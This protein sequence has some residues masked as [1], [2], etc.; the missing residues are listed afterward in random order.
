VR[1]EKSPMT[2]QTVRRLWEKLPVVVRA[3]VVGYL[4]AAI[5][6][7]PPSLFLLGNL[8]FLPAVPWLLP[9]TAVWLWLF[10]QYCDGKGWPRS[11]AQSR[12]RD[13]RGRPLPLRLWLWSLVAGSLGMVAMVG[14]AFLTP[15][16]AEIP[17]DAFKLPID[18]ADY[19]AWTVAAMLLAISAVAG[20]VEE[21]A[22]RGYMLSP[23]QRR[24][25]WPVAILITGLVFFADHHFGHAYATYA[26][27]PFFLAVSALHGLLVYLTRSILPSVVLH[28][29]ADALVIPIQY[30][31]IGNLS[32]SS[33][34]KHG[35]DASF[36]MVLGTVV[37]FGLA[38]VPAFAKLAAVA[39][40]EGAELPAATGSAAYR[41]SRRSDSERRDHG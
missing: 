10:W 36:L 18:F 22:F 38:A 41:P 30:G 28:A 25:G 6:G 12:H 11:T 16:L 40:A 7:L 9:A 19:P 5:G 13:L 33:V 21:A 17:R 2:W 29:V 27:L 23:I 31:I 3:I 8:K 4:V 15:R 32:V 1:D 35:V 26:F 14:L 37:G 24:H 39:A 20:V 34:W